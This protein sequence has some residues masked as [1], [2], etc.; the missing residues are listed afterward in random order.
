MQVSLVQKGGVVAR[1]RF[2]H[3]PPC[4]SHKNDRKP[5]VKALLT[6]AR[7]VLSCWERGDLAEAVRELG[8]AV[9]R[10]ER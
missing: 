8:S 7:R 6:A 3:L 2:L 9:R 1:T 5:K 10:F 4:R